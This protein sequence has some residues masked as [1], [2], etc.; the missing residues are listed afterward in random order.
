MSKNKSRN[1]KKRRD[2]ITK[3]IRTEKETFEYINRSTEIR[4]PFGVVAFAAASQY[5]EEKLKLISEKVRYLA[6]VTTDDATEAEEKSREAFKSGENFMVVLSSKE[7]PHVAS[8]AGMIQALKA[9]G[10]VDVL[11]ICINQKDPLPNDVDEKTRRTLQC[12]PFVD[13]PADHFFV[14]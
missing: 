3:Q 14:F 5:T 9:A 13:D 6:T 11:E 2:D 8:R 12:L 7:S 10:A 4:R 1:R